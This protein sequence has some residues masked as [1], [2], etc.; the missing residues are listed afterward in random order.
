MDISVQILEIA[1]KKTQFTTA[2]VVRAAK[3]RWTRQYIS[4]KIKQLVEQGKLVKSGSTAKAIYALPKNAQALGDSVTRH[5]LRAGAKEHEV[6]DDINRKTP[7]LLSL[8]ENLRYLLDY[9]FS[10]MLNNALDHSKSKYVDIKVGM[11]SKSLHFTV[12][13]L[14]IGVF[15]N[16][17]HSRHLKSE[18]EAMQDLLKGK[19]TTQ[20]H[21]HSGEGIFFTSKV[22]DL[23]ILESYGYVLR[24]D[25]R[26]PDVFFEEVSPSKRGTRVH[27]TIAKNTHKHLSDIFGKYETNP[28][29]PDFDK[30]EIHVKLYKVG[31]VYV[32]R[33]QARRILSGLEKFKHIILNFEDVPTVGQGF[34][35]EIFR[36]FQL[37][38]PD[39][40]ITP[41]HMN[42]AVKYMIDRVDKP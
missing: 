3:G 9:A 19:T 1:N 10:E 41:V 38:Y 31:T 37:K 22:A 20:P 26:I 16:V 29:E 33:S 14:G 5:L 13:D 15:R 36:V 34:A 24:I 2:D 18:F 17:M 7:F 12:S 11:D 39:I 32:S 8:N 27:F 6:L 42:E 4:A 25:N 23:F 21:A 40:V 35:D 28:D 30:T